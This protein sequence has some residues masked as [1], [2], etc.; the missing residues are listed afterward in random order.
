MRTL[1]FYQVDVFTDA[2]FAGHVD[3]VLVGGGVRPV[4]WGEMTL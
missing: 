2:P 3:D 4:I 1:R